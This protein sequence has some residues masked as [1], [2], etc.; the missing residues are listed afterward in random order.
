[1]A[2]RL[3]GTVH[4]QRLPGSLSKRRP[5]QNGQSMPGFLRRDE[6]V[7][8]MGDPEAGYER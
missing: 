6:K 1:M 2:H 7:A 5:L 3:Q 4:P 8:G